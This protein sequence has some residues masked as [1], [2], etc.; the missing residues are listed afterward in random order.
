MDNADFKNLEKYNIGKKLSDQSMITKLEN[1]IRTDNDH[2]K[3][4]K[5]INYVI[6]E[7]EYIVKMDTQ[8]VYGFNILKHYEIIDRF[9]L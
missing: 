2:L 9:R 6:Y 8:V 7:N 1:K 5:V 4:N 3:L